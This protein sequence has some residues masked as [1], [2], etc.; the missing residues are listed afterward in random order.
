MCAYIIYSITGTGVR[1]LGRDVA[2]SLPPPPRAAG[3]TG[4]PLRPCP[5]TAAA[6]SLPAPAPPPPRLLLS[7]VAPVQPVPRHRR[8]DRRT[9][10]TRQRRPKQPPKEPRLLQGPRRDPLKGGLRHPHRPLGAH[11]RTRK[12]PLMPSPSHPHLPRIPPPPSSAPTRPLRS[13]LMHSP[14]PVASPP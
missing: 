12:F 14:A 8:A 6:L 5:P 3:S 1:W 7:L 11:R 9:R 2:R 13:I 4:P 10:G